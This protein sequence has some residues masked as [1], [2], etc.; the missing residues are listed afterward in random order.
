MRKKTPIN[1]DAAEGDDLRPEY[2]F[3][4]QDSKPNRF[5]EEAARGGF[6]VLIDED[7]AEVFQTPES[8]KNVLR[9]IIAT[10]PNRAR[11]KSTAQ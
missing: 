10:M 6:M 5:A 11:T 2:H 7:I 4:Y 1:D 3:D 9:A 8:I